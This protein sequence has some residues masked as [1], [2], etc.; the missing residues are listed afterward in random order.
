M[1]NGITLLLLLAAGFLGALATLEMKKGVDKHHLF[2]L[3]YSSHALKGFLFMALSTAFYLAAL[4]KE[5][6][7]VVYPLVSTTYIWITIFS[8]KQLGEKMNAWKWIGLIGVLIGVI[9]VGIG[10]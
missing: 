4:R 6:L 2:R 7:S 5:E 1:I 9:L 3:V 10:S 8:V